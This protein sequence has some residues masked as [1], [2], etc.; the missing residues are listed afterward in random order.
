MDFLELYRR[1]GCT[2][3]IGGSDQWGNITAGIDLIRRVERRVGARAGHAAGHQGRRHE[4]RQDRGRHGLARPRL[5]SPYAFYQFWVN[6]EDARRRRAT[7][8]VFTLPVARARSRRWSGDGGAPGGARGAARARRG[9]HR[10]WC[11]A[12]TPRRRCEAA[13]Q[14]LFGR[15]ELADLDADDPGR[16]AGR[17]AVGH[18]C[19]RATTTSCDLLADDRAGRE[20]VGGP[21][22]DRGGRRLREQR[23]GSTR[24]RRRCPPSR[25]PARPLAGAAPGPASRS[26]AVE[27]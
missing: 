6:A 22:G 19:R 18:G 14:A 12:R 2:L 4:V 5:T 8:K 23:R 25:R 15:G 9:G 27:L 20:P 3:Q 24:R 11:T 21:A 16:R 10:R 7:C 26:A 17:A 13:S 1:H